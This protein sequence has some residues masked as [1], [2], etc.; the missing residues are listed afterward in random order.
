[1][2]LAAQRPALVLFRD[3]LRLSD[4][5]A[6]N[7]ACRTGRP[8]ACLFAYDDQTHGLRAHG[9][10]QK[11]WLHHSLVSLKS[12][13]EAGGHTLYIARGAADRVAAAA[14]EHINAEFVFWNRRY[15]DA[16]S[17][18]DQ[19]L[20]TRLMQ[21]K[22]RAEEFNGSLLYDPAKI[23]TKTGEP[24]KVFTPFWRAARAAG[25]PPAPEMPPGAARFNWPAE[26]ARNNLNPAALK[27]L[28]V[29]P[30]WA[31]G[32]RASWQPGEAGAQAALA[33]FLDEALEGYSEGRD[34]PDKASTSKL[35][36]HLRFGEISPRQIW[37]AARMRQAERGARTDKDTE[38]FLA[39]VGW[40]EFSYN[41][42]KLFP[43]LPSENFQA[44]FSAMPWRTDAAQLSAWQKGR[45]G[46]PIVDAGMR[47]LWR[48]GW[49]HNRVRMVVA[50]FL[51]KHLLIDWRQ[52]EEWFWDTLFDGD[53]AS[54]A[55]SWQWVA[56]SGADAAPF[57][58]IFNPILQG[59][60]FDP[61]GTYVRQFVPELKDVPARYIHAP[62]DAPPLELAAA[63]VRLGETYPHP[64]V[65]HDA[66]RARALEAYKAVQAE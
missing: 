27:L 29:S 64:I 47:Q 12:A 38:K 24:F 44:K 65:D 49:M 3:D 58:R 42:L 5:P 39:E 22:I 56:G 60:K 36:P 32:L 1:M 13:L 66:A 2:A 6:F 40:R 28:P 62:W 31:A 59:L 7:A 10:A 51:T 63:G 19:T 30:D 18:L 8:V 21:M 54:N 48:T 9:G 53:H 4:N 33:R 57:Y 50:S 61:E 46:Y 23:R 17:R 11:W 43:K 26:I 52:G 15:R 41:L 45:T 14:A 16:D 37:Q 34:R 55:A 25:E 35:S 20:M